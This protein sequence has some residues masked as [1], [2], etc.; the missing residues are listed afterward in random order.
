LESNVDS[1]PPSPS[2]LSAHGLSLAP[3]RSSSRSSGGRLAVPSRAS[4]R[5]SAALPDDEELIFD[6]ERQRGMVNSRDRPRRGSRLP[7]ASSSQASASL[8]SSG[9]RTF[10]RS[11]AQASGSATASANASARL[12]STSASAHGEQSVDPKLSKRAR[13]SVSSIG[14]LITESLIIAF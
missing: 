6:G 1:R 12:V 13:R 14:S 2:R 10:V 4:S 3:S 11:A 8:A 5:A 7:T 9:S